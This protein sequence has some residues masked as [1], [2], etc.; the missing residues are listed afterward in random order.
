MMLAANLIAL[1]RVDQEWTRRFMLQNLDWSAH[2]EEAQAAWIGFLW[3][4]RLY[5]P[6]LA[7]IKAAFLHTARHYSALGHFRDQYADLLTFVALE[8]P[9]PFTKT[10]L[11]LATSELPAEGLARCALSLVH[12]LDSAG[13]KRMEYWHNHIRAYVKDV[14]P[15]PLM[16]FLSP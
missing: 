8:A 7:S 13:E 1:F 10:E 4:P 2:G 5:V 9:E 11:A 15:K 16:P 14:W 3:A 12:A 6:L